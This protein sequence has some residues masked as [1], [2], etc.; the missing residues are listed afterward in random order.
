MKIKNFT[1][2]SSF[3]SRDPK[4]FEKRIGLISHRAGEKSL[5]EKLSE[6]GSLSA[7]T[8]DLPVI[9]WNE[10]GPLL[11]E[12]NEHVKGLVHNTGELPSSREILDIFKEEPFVI[13]K[14]TDRPLVK[15]MSF[16]IIGVKGESEEEFKTYG[17]FKKSERQFDFFK[18]KVL[19]NSRFEVLASGKN[20]LHVHKKINRTPFDVDIKR[21]D[22]LDSVKDICSKVSEACSPEFYIISLIESGGKLYLESI[23]RDQDLTPPQEFSL[24]EAAY[25]K[26]YGSSLPIWFKK[27]AFEDHVKP[28]YIKKYYDSLLFKPTGVI[29][30]KKYV[31]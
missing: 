12:I 5:F 28:Y 23:N 10:K 18:E 11:P 29:D 3:Y 17:K 14:V 13:K 20:P 19:P 30:Y 4:N 22:H 21:W 16:P 25:S 8:R 9:V 24:Y 15:K 6:I 7:I 2:Y 27:K 1:D 26:Y 31:D